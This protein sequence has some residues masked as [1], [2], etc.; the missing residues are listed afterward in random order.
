MLRGPYRKK[1]S[2]ENLRKALDAVRG[3]MPLK[4]AVRLY[5]VP[6]TTLQDRHAGRV[7]QDAEKSGP[8]PVLTTAE[9]IKLVNYI[10]ECGRIGYPLDKKDIKEVVKTILDDDG[11]PNP[12]TDNRP[13]KMQDIG[14]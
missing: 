12:F 6:R 4:Q 7:S 2:K 10:K 14:F 13:G 5:E 1:Y 11:R 9:E 8:S 3:G